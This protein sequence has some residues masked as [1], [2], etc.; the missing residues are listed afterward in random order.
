MKEVRSARVHRLRLTELMP[1]KIDDV[2]ELL[3]HL[4]AGFRAL[5]PPVRM[6]RV[7]MELT[8]KQADAPGFASFRSRVPALHRR[9][10]PIHEAASRDD[11]GLRCRVDHRSRA[12]HIE[13]NRFLHEHVS[14]RGNS[15]LDLSGVRE[16]RQRDDQQIDLRIQHATQVGEGL[17]SETRSELADLAVAAPATRD[18]LHLI[19]QGTRCGRMARADSAAA[20]QAY[21]QSLHAQAPNVSTDCSIPGSP[22]SMRANSAGASANATVWVMSGNRFKRFSYCRRTAV[23]HSRGLFQR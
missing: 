22:A 1:R 14:S 5:P 23:C 2:N 13:R 18:E 6:Q 8:G 16:R 10:E 21:P 19:L 4:A 15:L 7:A 3:D 11:T 9:A 12:C 20:E 17:G